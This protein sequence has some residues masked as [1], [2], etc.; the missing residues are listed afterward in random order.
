M[1]FSH[2]SCT[3]PDQPSPARGSHGAQMTVST[4]LGTLLVLTDSLALRERG[5]VVLF[6]A[7]LAKPCQH[8]LESKVN[9]QFSIL[10]CF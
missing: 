3:L 2:A 4:G 1:H 10:P 7:R 6:W 9:S 5:S 8:P